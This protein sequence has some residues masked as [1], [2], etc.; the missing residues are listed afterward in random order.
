MTP[1]TQAFESL[2]GAEP[3]AG[4][5]WQPMPSPAAHGWYGGQGG[6]TVQQVSP[7]E[8]HAEF[9]GKGKGHAGA[10]Y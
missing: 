1:R 10:A 7:L 6:V 2:G 5:A 4:G 9:I 3:A 8:E